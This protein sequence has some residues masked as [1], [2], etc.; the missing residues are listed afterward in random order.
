[1]FYFHAGPR[2][3]PENHIKI[4]LVG[5]LYNELMNQNLLINFKF[6][7]CGNVIKRNHFVVV[8]VFSLVILPSVISLLVTLLQIIL[9]FAILQPVILQPIILQLIISQLILL[10]ITLQATL[11]IKLTEHLA[12]FF[13]HFHRLSY[14]TTKRVLWIENSKK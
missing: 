14:I 6:I 4:T 12:T 7:S 2:L 5:K 10:L 9:L 11:K 3:F 8:T 13:H 1:M